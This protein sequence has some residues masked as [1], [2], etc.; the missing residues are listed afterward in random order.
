VLLLWSQSL[1]TTIRDIARNL[2]V[3]HSTVSKA[4]NRRTDAFISEAT[5]QRVE[6][7]AN[8]LGY[9]PNHAARALSTGKTNLI[10]LSIAD[11]RSDYSI[12]VMHHV[13]QL[14]E[15]RGY[16]MMVQRLPNSE[17]MGNL[18]EWPLDGLLLLD[19]PDHVEAL[20]QSSPAH[21]PIV[22]LGA[23]SGTQADHV[24][25][26]LLTG[27]QQAMAH[28]IQHGY[29]RIIYTATAWGV[30]DEEPRHQ[31]YISSLS[32]IDLDSEEFFVE[33]PSRGSAYSTLIGA[34]AKKQLTLDQRKTALFCFN[35]DIALGCYRAL[36]ES[37]IRVPEDIGIVGCD[38][39]EAIQYLERPISTISYSIR[40]LCRQGLDFLEARI[41]DPTLA[42]Q[43][44]TIPSRFIPRNST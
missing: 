12:R 27:A 3:S 37:G 24:G 13:D 39:S 10:G 4:L 23:Y 22:N 31:A 17:Q 7:E 1:R 38:D 25:I 9:R 18:L 19:F 8:R 16:Q 20:L 34:L 2:N 21:V 26:D 15:A 32:S 43:Y 44:E 36:S 28:L 40:E 41:E 33:Q 14:L 42:I 29:E 6:D 5:R 30:R 35:D 11:F